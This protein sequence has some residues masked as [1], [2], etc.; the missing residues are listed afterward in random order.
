MS[1]A[2]GGQVRWRRDGSELFYIALDGQ[3]M[4]MPIRLDS[5][6][7][8]VDASAPVSLFATRVGGAMQPMAQQYIVS[9][10]G[11][12]FLMNT[13]VEQAASP[14]TIVLNWVQELN[15]RVPTK[16]LR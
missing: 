15:A 9:A 6:G 2:G 1:P 4:A 12:R 5:G 3:L 14:I 11:Q 16:W 7:R 13:V 10:D 8:L